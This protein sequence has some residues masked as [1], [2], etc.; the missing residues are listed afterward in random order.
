MYFVRSRENCYSK[1]DSVRVGSAT[2]K[3]VI[4][5]ATATSP[6]IVTCVA[7]VNPGKKVAVI[8]T[9]TYEK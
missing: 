4:V 5:I 2:F 1:L 9:V 6:K 7:T 3:K 8:A